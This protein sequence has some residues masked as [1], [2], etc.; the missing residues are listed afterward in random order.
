MV[1]NI[2]S[3]TKNNKRKSWTPL[4]STSL[5]HCKQEP[6]KPACHEELHNIQTELY[7]IQTELQNIQTE[8]YN[9]QTDT[10][11]L[12]NALIRFCNVNR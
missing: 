9:I 7:N 1:D 12:K 4:F 2:K 11:K 5:K 8:L 10:L 6:P 3:S